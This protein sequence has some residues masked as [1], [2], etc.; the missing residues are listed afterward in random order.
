MN[1]TTWKPLKDIEEMF[2]YHPRFHQ[3]NRNIATRQEPAST[4]WSPAVDI[5]ESD[6]EFLIKAE[7]PEVKKED[8]N[9]NISNG[10]LT[11]DGERRFE[12]ESKDGKKFHRIERFYGHFT[13][14]FSLPD[15]I[16]EANIKAEFKEGMLTVHLKKSEKEAPKNIR[17]EIAA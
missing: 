17:V 3:S 8:V 16:K 10:V 2:H 1:L 12:Q 5:I 14:S 15:N 11:I 13:R 7:L 6:H 9:V 4:E